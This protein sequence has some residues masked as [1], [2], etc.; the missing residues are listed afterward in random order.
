MFK[1]LDCVALTTDIPD[2]GLRESDVGTVV[3]AYPEG[4]AF[5]VEFL[6][7]DGSTVAVTEVQPSQIRAVTACDITHARTIK[8]QA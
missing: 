4:R 8:V 6:T 7:L 1:E 2:E 3:H 5:I